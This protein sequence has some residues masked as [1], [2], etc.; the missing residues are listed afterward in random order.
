M[1]FVPRNNTWKTLQLN[2]DKAWN[3]LRTANGDVYLG[4]I[5]NAKVYRVP[6]P[7][8]DLTTAAEIADGAALGI[9]W[10][11]P[12]GRRT[13][14]ESFNAGLNQVFL[15]CQIPN[16]KD[17]FAGLIA[18]GKE[19]QA[20]GTITAQQLIG[21][22]ITLNAAGVVPQAPIPD[23]PVTAPQ[24]LAVVYRIPAVGGGFTGA[25]RLFSVAEA[26]SVIGAQ[27]NS[28][29]RW[30]PQAP[31][32]TFTNTSG[33]T[34]ANTINPT[35]SSSRRGVGQ[36][37]F[38]TN[39]AGAAQ[40]QGPG[41]AS[42]AFKPPEHPNLASSIVF[43]ENKPTTLA[44]QPTERST[45][46]LVLWTVATR[47]DGIG[48]Q[49]SSYSKDSIATAVQH[50][51]Y[52]ADN[53]TFGDGAFTSQSST[54][55]FASNQADLDTRKSLLKDILPTF[56]EFHFVPPLA[57]SSRFTAG[58]GFTYNNLGPMATSSNYAYAALRG[59]NKAPIDPLRLVRFDNGI[60]YPNT[61]A[62]VICPFAPLDPGDGTA[63][64]NVI[65]GM[66]FD[67][68][69]NLY[70]T[71]YKRVITAQTD[72]VT[73]LPYEEFSAAAPDHAGLW[74]WDYAGTIG[75]ASAGLAVR[76]LTFDFVPESLDYVGDDS[77]GPRFMIPTPDG[78]SRLVSVDA[79]EPAIASAGP[80]VLGDAV[81]GESILQTNPILGVTTS[82]VG[83]T[84][85]FFSTRL[86]TPDGPTGPLLTFAL[87]GKVP[88]S[89]KFL[90]TGVIGAT[91]RAIRVE[92]ALRDP[93]TGALSAYLAASISNVRPG[94][95][96]S[97]QV[98]PV[99][100]SKYMFF[101]WLPNTDITDAQHLVV[102][103]VI[104]VDPETNIPIL[105]APYALYTGNR[106]P[107]TGGTALAPPPI[108]LIDARPPATFEITNTFQDEATKWNIEI[109][110]C[111]PTTMVLGQ[112]VDLTIQGVSFG[113]T[114][115]EGQKVVLSARDPLRN[116]PAPLI[117]SILIRREIGNKPALNV[118]IPNKLNGT[119]RFP[120]W[121]YD[122]S[123][124]DGQIIIRG[125]TMPEDGRF[126]IV[127][128]R[129]A[130]AQTIVARSVVGIF[131][132]TK[133]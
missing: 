13:F 30:S 28:A 109:I 77:K 132:V 39:V 102:L 4:S 47:T 117:A 129:K 29:A 84:L 2:A 42:P 106:P 65:S 16:N 98:G 99:S 60:D 103:R 115:E 59:M 113:Q 32:Y 83:A 70:V 95:L 79:P 80:L 11:K 81:T 41:I 63:L 112:R 96:S 131:T 92:Y 78:K 6:A 68:Q 18:T 52:T 128:L 46:P 75:G 122:S 101:D 54:Q 116:I 44:A 24:K 12:I 3:G 73:G 37:S 114:V 120:F 107:P 133:A 124:P 15:A 10:I 94:N 34:L 36:N 88:I 72:G 19:F 22:K 119:G 87:D 97:I 108:Y 61:R 74:W 130:A 9:D 40:G 110:G 121:E 20:T 76:L 17:A 56:A 7:A 91:P 125:L 8:A 126:R 1:A 89:F 85:A 25:I 5:L 51:S 33:T 50:V 127:F 62:A 111:S 64:P 58:G 105:V 71:A 26:G 66:T 90:V 31:F 38:A 53:P 14:T 100:K 69:G 48:A 45:H 86:L 49:A 82:G 93:I 35:A 23:N 55:A 123:Q 67:A 21:T 57:G 27:I 43:M 104:S 118:V